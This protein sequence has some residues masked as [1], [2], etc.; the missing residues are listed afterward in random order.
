LLRNR[1]PNLPIVLVSGYDARNVLDGQRLDD[2][3]EFLSKPF[4]RST[5]QTSIENAIE[6]AG[7]LK[8]ERTSSTST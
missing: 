4:S 5:L 1:R 6:Q 2:S 8:T 3:V 7:S